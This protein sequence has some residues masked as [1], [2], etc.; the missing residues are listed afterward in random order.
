[1]ILYACPIGKAGAPVHPCARATDALDRAGH[2]YELRTVKGGSLKPWTWH[3][4][5]R[6]RA[7]IRR[8]SGQLA[9]PILVL[10]DGEVVAG[11]G[12]I[13]HWA[14]EHQPAPATG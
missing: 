9:V 8:L 3:R 12:A 13:A 11:S 10:D 5:E 4:R 1:V 7:E 6:D 2:A 14:R